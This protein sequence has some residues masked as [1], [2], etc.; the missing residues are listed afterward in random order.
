MELDN[1]TQLAP[2]QTQLLSKN[3]EWKAKSHQT[4]DLVA[5]SEDTSEWSPTSVPTEIFKDL[6]EAGRI[7]DHR[8]DLNEREVQ[9]VGETD[10][11]YRTKFQ[12]DRPL[13][14]DEKAALVFEGLDT[15]ATVYLNGKLI[16][17]SEV[18]LSV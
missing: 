10:W 14:K 15:F 18:C 2:L 9:W 12:F 6:L 8:F 13:Q 3:W 17:E 1:D 4:P 7:P 5:L 16:L 11:L